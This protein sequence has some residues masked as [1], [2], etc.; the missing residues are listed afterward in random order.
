MVP[1]L[2]G[3]SSPLDGYE[4]KNAADERVELLDLTSLLLP[5]NEIELQINATSRPPVSAATFYSSPGTMGDY[6]RVNMLQG[7]AADYAFTDLA[8]GDLLIRVI[9]YRTADWARGCVNTETSPATELSD[10]R[11]LALVD[12]EGFSGLLLDGTKGRLRISV[13]LASSESGFD[14]ESASIDGKPVKDLVTSLWARQFEALPDVPDVPDD[15]GFGPKALGRWFGLMEGIGGAAVLLTASIAGALMGILRDRGS[16]ET[17]AA[18]FA[19][20]VDM[21]SSERLRIVDATRTVKRT[22]WK[23]TWS[24]LAR[25]AG[26][27]AV[28]G[29]LLGALPY[30][31]L[32]AG[33]M[34]VV[35]IAYNLIRART[36]SARSPHPLVLP[37]GA[38]AVLSTGTAIAG[39]TVIAGVMLINAACIGALLVGGAIFWVILLPMACMGLAVM[40][41]G[42][43]VTRF[44]QRLVRPAVRHAIQ[45]DPRTPVMLLRSFQDDS[46]EVRAST[47]VDGFAEGV[48]SEGYARFEEIIALALTGIGPVVT[49]GQPGAVLQPLGAAR[50]YF[51]DDQWQDAVDQRSAEASLLAVVTGRSPALMWEIAQ[52]RQRGYLS[53]TV[54]IFPPV[55]KDELNRRITVLWSA[56]SLDEDIL[57]R[58]MFAYPVALTFTPEGLPCLHLSRARDETAYTSTLRTIATNASAQTGS[59]HDPAAIATGPQTD[60]GPLLERFN[61]SKATQ[62]RRSVAS[63]AWDI[64]SRF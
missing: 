7:E 45:S 63:I 9:A 19:R 44:T 33:I 8:G 21:P 16:R 27:A 32:T 42:R 31:W 12:R 61:P 46:L 13:L 59:L 26:L 41:S 20:P 23:A 36:S 34:A 5:A 47:A 1:L 40:T 25:L 24:W 54:F 14:P 35:L 4:A 62:P 43:S 10:G 29:F 22:A 28:F 51:A 53:K 58:D 52:I 38:R 2:A 49:L 57:P 39:L 50:D 48:G 64:A 55:T 17:F 56:L 18:M 6:Q 37:V 30:W 60:V 15:A 3:C 11:R